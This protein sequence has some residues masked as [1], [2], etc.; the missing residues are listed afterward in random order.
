MPQADWAVR[1]SIRRLEIITL[2]QWFFFSINEIDGQYYPICCV[3]KSKNSVHKIYTY[4]IHFYKR[5][6]ILHILFSIF[7]IQFWCVPLKKKTEIRFLESV[8]VEY[9][10]FPPK[11]IYIMYN[12]ILVK[13]FLFKIF[14]I[15]NQ[16]LS[17]NIVDKKFMKTQKSVHTINTSLTCYCCLHFVC[18]SYVAVSGYHA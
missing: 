18:V 14:R 16:C 3:I 13:L 2:L 4:C 17:E 10:A 12:C 1:L 6:K 9:F 5:S 15:F 11:L 7:S 8:P